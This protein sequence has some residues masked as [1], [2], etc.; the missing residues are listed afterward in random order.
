[1]S[2]IPSASSSPDPVAAPSAFVT[3]SLHADLLQRSSPGW[4][5][6]ASQR[7]REALK[8]TDVA[9][10]DWYR[11]ASRDQR[12]A[13]G[14]AL[15]ASLAAQARLDNAMSDF[16]DIDRF[17]APLLTQALKDQF[18]VTLD[19]N[20]TWL[21]LNKPVEVGIFAIEIDSFQV[22]KLPLLQAALHNFEARECKGGAFHRTSGFRIET[23]KPG[24]LEP[25]TTRLTVE[26][27]TGLC[28]SL[29]IGAKY[30]DYLKAFLYPKDAVARNVLRDKFIDAHK[31]ALRA[32]AEVALLTGDIG[33]EDYASIRSILNG[34]LAPRQ[35]KRQIWFCDLGLMGRRMTGCVL[36]AICEKY[37]YSDDSILYIPG[38]PY[39]PLKRYKGQEIEAMFKQRFTARDATQAHPADPNAYQRF[40]SQFV[41]YADRSY[42][43]SQ[44]TDDKPGRTALQRLTP[45]APLLNEAFKAINPISGTFVGIRELPPAPAVEQVPN[46]DPY[47]NPVDLSRK[48]HGIWADNV[49]LWEYLFDQHRDRLIADARSHAVPTADVDARVRSEKL[50]G[51][52]NLG[53]L[54]LTGVSMFVPV[55]GELMM[56]VMAGQLLDETFEGAI[57]WSEGD[58]K[59]AKAHLIDVAQNLALIALM[60]GGGKAFARLTTA[61]PLPAIENLHQVQMP[62]GTTRLWKPD[63][64]A[65]ESP[66]K[67]DSRAAPNALGQYEV[68]QDKYIQLD[69]K[70]YRQTY[71]ESL[72]AWRISHPSDPQAYQPPLAHNGAG[73]WRHTLERPQRWDRLK[74]LRRI[75][76]STDAFADEQLLILGDVAGV[77]DEALRKMHLDNALPPPELADA[78]R[79]F[80]AERDAGLIVEQVAGTQPIDERYLQVLPLLPEMPRWPWGRQLQVYESPDLSGSALRYGTRRGGRAPIRISLAEVLSGGLPARILASLDEAEVVGLLGD[81]P[82]RVAAVRP[83]ELARQIGDF[84]DARKPALLESLLRPVDPVAPRIAKLQRSQPG[85][86]E[87]AAQTVLHQAN[88]DELARLDSSPRVPLHLQELSR[89]YAGE[90]RLTRAMAGLHGE[91]MASNDSARLALHALSRLPGWPG[92]VRLELRAGGVGGPL[93][94]AIGS[95]AAPHHKFVVRNGTAWQAFDDRAETLNSMPARGDNFYASLMHALPD[96]ARRSIGL[97]QVGQSRELQRAIIDYARTHRT[98]CAQVF[99]PAA[100]WFRPP[101]RMASGRLG[102]PASGESAGL[103]PVLTSHVQA[104]YPGLSDAQARGFILEQWRLGKTDQQIFHLLNNRMSEWRQLETTLDQWSMSPDLRQRESRDAIM[105]TAQSIK[106]GWRNAPL[107]GHDPEAARLTL[108]SDAPLPPLAADFA[109]VRELTLRAPAVAETLAVFPNVERLTLTTST[110]EFEKTLATLK[111]LRHMTRLKLSTPLTATV[112]TRLRELSRL[113]EFELHCTGGGM[114]PVVPTTLDVS[115]MRQLRRLEVN[116]LQMDQ[117]PRGVLD[118]PRLERL[119]LRSTAIN[120]LPVDIYEGHQRLLSGLS[121]DWSRFTRR[122]FKPIYE[123]VRSQPRHLLDLDEM[124]ADYCRGELKR[125]VRMESGLLDVLNNGFKAQFTDAMSRFAAIETLSEQ[126]NELNRLQEWVGSEPTVFNGGTARSEVAEALMSSWRSGLLQRYGTRTESVFYNLYVSFPNDASVLDIAGSPMES[127]P[128]LSPEGFNHVRNLYLAGLKAP[129]EQM[130]GFLRTFQHLD[131]L[132]LSDCNLSAL[133]L[134]PGDLPTLETLNLHDNPLSNIDVRGMNRLRALDLSKTAIDQ[135]PTGA[136]T[137]PELTWLDLSDSRLTSLPQALLSRDQLL[138]DTSLTDT[139]LSPQARADLAAARS[140]I[141]DSHGL[142]AGSLQRFA[143]EEPRHRTPP[144]E[145][146]SVVARR[147]LP[148]PPL[149]T[150]EGPVTWEARLRRLRPDYD[151]ARAQTSIEQMR[152]AG[153]V[154]TQISARI[155]QWE[156][157]FESLT[158]RLNDWLFTHETRGTHWVVSS[159]SRQLAAQRIIRCWREGS[160]DWNGVADH[161]LSLDGLQVGNLPELGE[162][163]PAV[164]DLNLSGVKLT[165]SGSNGFLGAFTQLRRLSLSGNHLLAIPEPVAQMRLLERLE[166]SSTGLAQSTPMYPIL[167]G[168][169]QLRWLDLS[170]NSLYTFDVTGLGRLERLDL[171]DNLLAAWPDGVLQLPNLQAVDL[172]SNEIASIP[173]ELYDGTHTAL[174]AS[175]N[176]SENYE[177]SQQSL[178]RLRAYA[179][180][181]GRHEVLGITYA[182]IDRMIDDMD[183]TTESDGEGAGLE[184]EPEPDEVLLTPAQGIL[185]QQAA[186]W[187]ESVAQEDV[188]SYR[189]MWQ[190]LAGEPDNAAFFHLLSRM[191]DTEEFRVFRADLTRR[192]WKIVETIDGSQELRDTVFSMAT[193]HSTCVDG[194][195]LAFSEIEVKVFE[196]NALRHLQP[197]LAEKGRALLDLSRQ[198][199]R[200]GEVEKLAARSMDRHADPAEVRLQYRIGLTSG[201]EDGLQLPGQPGQMRFARPIR[202]EEL[203]AARAAVV[204]AEKSVRFYEDLISREYWVQYLN[205]KY[206]EAFAALGRH[207]DEQLESLEGEHEDVSSTAYREAV[208]MLEV[209]RSIERN[210]KLIELSHLETGEPMPTATEG[211]SQDLMN[212]SAR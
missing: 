48:G 124:V 27:F 127:L 32:A 53:M 125:F 162:S 13:V 164:S 119:N 8:H 188:A 185:E 142:V 67:L 175:S 17:A 58:R 56:G 89:E 128:T 154:D 34:E 180:T 74:L 183:S 24:T 121:L 76:H 18:N 54:V 150:G 195:T 64:S 91:T 3:Q 10:P 205:E 115:G 130:R 47:L 172:S 112:A 146:G 144:M 51:L 134:E 210:T 173:S 174:I 199:F 94:D 114:N 87:R 178:V 104:L 83:L 151:A 141:E 49:D 5:I 208:Q 152:D 163:M 23:S 75:G 42:Y 14:D 140:R 41:A 44:F 99:R 12:K 30:Q 2:E 166:L 122:V 37:R 186:P 25:L 40:F 160:I 72:K 148:L 167:Q 211:T 203:A 77:S 38:D 169:E 137:L 194:R 102:Y 193:T 68:G 86:T 201:W 158:R 20:K 156:Q 129:L 33:R 116:A 97:P 36:F 165:T 100:R 187:M 98:A 182:D 107:A 95:E 28:R 204:K 209:E 66:V 57:E 22:L 155:A 45:Y 189:M 73:A 96:E 143:L 170:H 1:M 46:P 80:R 7:Q 79:L 138:L 157:S 159:R 117:W 21:V 105:H 177:I 90:G 65:Y 106:D 147:L 108:I 4:L 63:L 184:S 43:F 39:H 61:R 197:G 69:G 93:I 120:S 168:L 15:T 113:E 133:P 82:A 78:M 6:D 179:D 131:T 19:V 181:Q 190:R 110:A 16:Q 123:F 145:S 52:L 149:P 139:P 132:D 81:E 202:G 71:D 103:D 31:T 207:A 59:A 111:S 196:Y 62:D 84:A 191:P 26:Q 60:S 9:T 171:R 198:L 50:A 92:D 212:A 161:E 29:D 85:L 200:L 109:H 118:L 176:L 35:G 192:V 70:T 88:A 126:F 135:W 55:L 101:R 11:H 206:P 153:L 136:E